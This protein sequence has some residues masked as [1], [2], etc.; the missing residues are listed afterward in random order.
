MGCSCSGRKGDQGVQGAQGET[1]PQGAAGAATV[2]QVIVG[3]TPI[4]SSTNLQVIA[5][6]AQTKDLMYFGQFQFTITG[7]TASVMI[8]ATVTPVVAGIDQT[9]KALTVKGAIDN[10]GELFFVVP[11]SDLMAVVTGNLIEFKVD[12]D[13]YTQS[14]TAKFRINYSYQ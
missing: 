10:D 3:S 2:T 7:G 5:S 11:V 6:A 8:T 13:N 4:P 9:S 14:L 12:L 1:G